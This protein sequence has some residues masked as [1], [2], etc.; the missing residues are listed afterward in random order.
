MLFSSFAGNRDVVKRLADFINQGRLPHAI[1]L[2][3]AQGSGRRTLAKIIAAGAVCAD[4]VS[5]PCGRCG[6]CVKADRLVHPD[7]TL[8]SGEGARSF[9][10][11]VIRRV[12][13]DVYILPNE[14]EKKVYI[15]ANAQSMTEQAQN[16]LLKVLEEPPAHVVFILTCNDRR[17]LLPTIYSR[18]VTFTLHGVDSDEAFEAV[19][20]RAL[21]VRDAEIERAVELSGGYIGIALQLLE[22]GV[23]ASAFDL[24]GKIAAAAAAENELELLRLTAG[25]VKE[26]ELFRSVLSVLVL[27]FRDVLAHK[28]GSNVLISGLFEQC[29]GLSKKVTMANALEAAEVVEE[30]AR[31]IDSNANATLLCTRFCAALRRAAGR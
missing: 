4:P 23:L 12:R 16:A 8:I 5:K 7:I 1:I 21:K 13:N 27:V 10:I 14:A 25:L 26:K 17:E 15:L 18:A 11:D 19:K 28:S 22:N 20:A 30:T 24:A 29:E 6:H 9:H 3:G 31:A 2:E